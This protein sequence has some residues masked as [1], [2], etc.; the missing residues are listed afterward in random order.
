MTLFKKHRLERFEKKRF[1]LLIATPEVL[2]GGI[3]PTESSALTLPFSCKLGIS[4]SVAITSGQLDVNTTTGR[5]LGTKD[6]AADEIH[7]LGFLE[8]GIEITI[9]PTVSLPGIASLYYLDQ[10][11]IPFVIATATFT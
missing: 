7:E 10:W 6:L 2:T 8:R 11:K 5:V 4:F 1:G 3:S 9:E